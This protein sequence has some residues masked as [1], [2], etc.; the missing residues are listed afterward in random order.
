MKFRGTV[1]EARENKIMLEEELKENIVIPIRKKQIKW[2]NPTFMIMKAKVQSESQPYLTFEFQNNHYTYR[3]I[4]FGTKSSPIYFVKAMETIIQQVKMNIE[5]RVINY[6]DDILLLHKN[7][8]NLKNMTQR[9]IDT[10]KY[11][12]FIKNTKKS[13]TEPNQT[14]IFLRWKWNQTNSTAKMKL[15]KQIL[16]LHDLYYM[17]RLI[18]SGK[19][20]TVKQTVKLIRKINYLRQQFLEASLLL[21]TT[22]HQN[23]QAARLKRWN[24]T[25]IMN[26]NAIPDIN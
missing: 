10:F 11:F 16:F 7:K 23:A 25:M 8:E 9:V 2:Y 13:Q 17:R 18:K 5:T 20:I 14:A 26:M 6:V 4:P 3:T 24:T 19:E 15:K 21:H 22:D 12:R 1:E